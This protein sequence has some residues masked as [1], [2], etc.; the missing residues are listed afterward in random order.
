MTL[1]EYNKRL[2]QTSKDIQSGL[3]QTMVRLGTEALTLLKK[4]VQETGKNAQGNN[5]PPYSQT[6]MLVGC[7]SMNK[8]VCTSF[9]GKNKN[10]ELEWVTLNRTNSEGK[11]IR[12]AVLEGGYKKLR[13]LHGRPTSFVD[14]SFSNDM[15]NDIKII[16]KSSEHG[17]GIV[18]IGAEQETEK[19]KLEGNT[20]R[21]GTILDL[22]DSEVRTLANDFKLQ[23]L[24]VIRN[25]GI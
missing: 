1:E 11:K 6:P 2:E 19:K 18:V 23:T 22:S 24:R 15:W 7:K 25:N 20:K 12:L 9:F 5:F 13:E 14:F 10:K 3:S 8:S 16:S 4:R 17:F 21:K